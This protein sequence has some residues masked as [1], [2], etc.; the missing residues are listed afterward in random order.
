M[1][2]HQAHLN[3]FKLQ[4]AA[5]KSEADYLK[6]DRCLMGLLE[7]ESQPKQLI[8]PLGDQFWCDAQECTGPPAWRT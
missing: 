5:G 4:S 7:F 3:D 1:L 2:I 8:C 6:G